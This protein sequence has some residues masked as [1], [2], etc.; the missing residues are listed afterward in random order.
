VILKSGRWLGCT[1][2]LD[3]VA[4]VVV[5]VDCGML[6]RVFVHFWGQQGMYDT[7]LGA[8]GLVAEVVLVVGID[9]VDLDMAALKVL[10]DAW[11]FV[12]GCTELASIVEYTVA[13]WHS[14]VLLAL[15]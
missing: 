4:V 2:T 8:F 3:S 12:G 15:W 13:S 11:T 1:L 9:E 5:V 14:A 6:W 10:V 7:D